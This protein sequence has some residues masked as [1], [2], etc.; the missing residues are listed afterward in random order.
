MVPLRAM[1]LSVKMMFHLLD[2]LRELVCY[3]FVPLPR[4][5]ERLKPGAYRYAPSPDGHRWMDE[6]LSTDQA[7]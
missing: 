6:F 5:W 1:L 4:Y 7:G 3:D 2:V